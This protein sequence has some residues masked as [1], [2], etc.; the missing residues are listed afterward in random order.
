MSLNI[1]GYLSQKIRLDLDIESSNCVAF[2]F[3]S[4]QIFY[5]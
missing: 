4:V 5:L 1:M 2:N 3:S